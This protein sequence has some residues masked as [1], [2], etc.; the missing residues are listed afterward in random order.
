MPF[1]VRNILFQTPR[2]WSPKRA[3]HE[4][5][6]C[7]NLKYRFC[8]E[9]RCSSKRY[10]TCNRWTFDSASLNHQ[11]RHAN[12]IFWHSC[13]SYKHSCATATSLK[14]AELT[15]QT[16]LTV[17]YYNAVIVTE[18][19]LRLVT[20]RLIVSKCLINVYKFLAHTFNILSDRRIP[21]W[22][23]T[24]ITCFDRMPTKAYTN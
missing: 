2:L 8:S 10:L 11:G 6:H 18:N 17:T 20:G 23:T 4:C 7:I 14:A 24:R 9:V 21:S 12:G 16:A 19:H 3:N 5:L 15:P 22:K 13:Q 1:S